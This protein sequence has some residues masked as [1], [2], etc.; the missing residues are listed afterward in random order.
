M[1]RIRTI[2]PEFW[3]SEQ[4]AECS[5][6]ARL[7]FIGMWNFCDDQGIHPASV[8][9]LKM[10]IFPGDSFSLSDI[11]NMVIEL[12]HQRLLFFYQTEGKNYWYVTGWNHQKID[13]PNKKHPLPDSDAVSR[14]VSDN[15]AKGRRKV[16]DHP[17]EEG[18]GEEGNGDGGEKKPTASKSELSFRESFQEKEDDLKRLFPDHDYELEKETCVAHYR[19]HPPPIDPYV[20]IVK[21]FRRAKPVPMHATSQGPHTQTVDDLRAKGLIE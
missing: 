4:V 6:N 13:K 14:F 9:T 3:T 15:S 8:K 7:L 11:E 5:P 17:P 16:D 2:K 20:V 18:N 19:K 12:M 21:W 10:Q 1:A